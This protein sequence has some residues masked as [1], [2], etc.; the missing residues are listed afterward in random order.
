MKM[1]EKVMQLEMPKE[2]SERMQ[3]LEMDVQSGI[4]LKKKHVELLDLFAT[5]EGSILESSSKLDELQNIKNELSKVTKGRED[6][7]KRWTKIVA[8]IKE[9]SRVGQLGAQLLEAVTNIS[10]LHPMYYTSTNQFLALFTRTLKEVPANPLPS[11]RIPALLAALPFSIYS[12]ISE[13]L[14][15]Q[16]KPVWQLTF[17]IRMDLHSGMS[18][19]SE[20]DAIMTVLAASEYEIE[21]PVPVDLETVKAGTASSRLRNRKAGG[22][23]DSLAWMSVDA[24][25]GMKQLERNFKVFTE[26]QGATLTESLIQQPRQWGAWFAADDP[27]NLKV[28]LLDGDIDMDKGLRP[29]EHLA[30][31]RWLRFDRF[32][33]AAQKFVSAVLDPRFLQPIAMD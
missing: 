7:K 32:A 33:Q 18:V 5:L 13:G 25:V 23:P 10:Y 21:R 27:E 30:L 20:I 2:A 12:H 29:V 19:Q 9:F 14:A 26:R 3:L 22:W 17:A 6:A 4:E 31:V 16:H 28:P 11:E 15:A 1:L 24:Y 8:S